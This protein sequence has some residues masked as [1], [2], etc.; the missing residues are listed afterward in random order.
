MD[1]D[2]QGRTFW[3]RAVRAPA[4]NA[5]EVQIVVVQLVAEVCGSVQAA[6]KPLARPK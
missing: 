2:D 4:T 6:D 1:L 5:A 3:R